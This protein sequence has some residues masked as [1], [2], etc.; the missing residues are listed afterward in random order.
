MLLD[1]IDRPERHTLKQLLIWIQEA[2]YV[3]SARG[4]L[5]NMSGSTYN[6]IGISGQVVGISG[7]DFHYHTTYTNPN[8]AGSGPNLE[9]HMADVIKSRDLLQTMDIESNDFA[10]LVKVISRYGGNIQQLK[11]EMRATKLITDSKFLNDKEFEELIDT[12]HVTIP[13]KK[14]PERSYRLSEDSYQ[15]IL[16]LED[17]KELCKLCALP[18]SYDDITRDTFTDIDRFVNRV[19]AVK[20]DEDYVIDNSNIYKITNN[21]NEISRADLK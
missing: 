19:M 3:M 11:K 18:D 20:N 1:E 13:S 21:Q 9:S 14:H 4:S 10:R 8:Y 12:N 16:V 6:Q 15:Q 2:R 7:L 5:L 17:G